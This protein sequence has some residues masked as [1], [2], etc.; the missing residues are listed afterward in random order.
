MDAA[1]K[2]LRIF[3][4]A[5]LASILLYILVAAA[6][7]TPGGKTPAPVILIALTFFAVVNVVVIL[8]M[9]RV[10][11]RKAED[12]L[13]ANPEDATALMRWRSGYILTYAI[14]EAIALFGLVVHFL[15]FSLL[16]SAPFFLAGFVVIVFFGPR[17][18]AAA[19]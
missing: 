14:A 16:Q 13:R 19:L 5:L 4:F 10:L 12:T 6:I 8:V 2:V 7:G 1:L 15:G 17:R 9:R 11:V 18:P 3:Q